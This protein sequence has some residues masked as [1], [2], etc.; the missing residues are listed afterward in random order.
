VDRIL[1]PLK[2][3]CEILIDLSINLDKL[4]DAKGRFGHPREIVSMLVQVARHQFKDS[5]SLIRLHEILL[6]LRAYPQSARIARLSDSLSESF[7]KRIEKLKES[8]ANI[9]GFDDPEVSGIAGTSVTDTFSFNIVRWLLERHPSQV[10]FDWEWFEDENRLAQTWPR[11]MPLLEEDAFVEANVPYVSWLT[12]AR[13]GEREVAWIVEQVERLQLTERERVEL[14]DSLK[15]YVRWKPSYRATRTGM[16]LRVNK[17]FYH[18]GPLIQRREIDLREELEKAGPALE[19]LSRMQGRRILDMARETSTLRYR[20]LYGFT[21]GDEKRVLKASLGRGVDLFVIGIPPERRLPLRAYHA[22][23][24]FK[25]GVPVGYFEGLSLFERMESGFNF[26]YS[27]REGETAWIYARTLNVFRHLLNVTAF[28]LDPYQLGYENEEGIESGAFW[29]YRK[30]GFR[31]TQPTLLKLAKNEEQKIAKR[32]SHRTAPQVLRR[33]AAGPM[34][35]ELEDAKTGD[36]DR[37]ALRNIGLAVQ[38]RMAARYQGAAVKIREDSVSSICRILS[39]RKSDFTKTEMATLSDFAVVLA[40]IPDLDHWSK[41]D[42][43]RLVGIV[44]AKAG[45]DEARYLKL[46][47]QHPR[48]RDALI[49]LGSHS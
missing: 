41:H 49:K 42:K 6:F 16:R 45:A 39:I 33:L 7:P 47:Q 8:R 12:A 19:R 40:L 17:L 37:F 35:F 31:P 44:R 48:L 46:M 27:F 21:H 36:W 3:S 15:L 29:F 26:Y 23:M 11:F 10:S 9:S 2:V 34:I 25:N 38:R 1:L 18:R 14:Y 13:D 4:E 22:A 5:K 24:I 20:E 28:S 43:D 32:A 30:L